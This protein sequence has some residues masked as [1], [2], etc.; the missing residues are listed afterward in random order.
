MES[1]APLVAIAVNNVMSYQL[2]KTASTRDK[3]TNLYNYFA[4][5]QRLYEMIEN[6]HRKQKPLTFVLMDIDDFKK[7]NDTYGHLAGNTVLAQLG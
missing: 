3:L 1:I 2:I 4:F 6:A 7:V 5:T